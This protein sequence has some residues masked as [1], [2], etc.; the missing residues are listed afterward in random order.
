MST[1]PLP[2]PPPPPTYVPI[3]VPIREY[4]NEH[5]PEDGV[6]F[7]AEFTNDNF[8]DD[9]KEESRITEA[10]KNERVQM[11]LMVRLQYAHIFMDCLQLKYITVVVVWGLVVLR[12]CIVFYM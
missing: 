2:P 9:R 11:Q 3:N 1:P 6:E 4:V 12:R 8:Y 10:E 7:S 5:L